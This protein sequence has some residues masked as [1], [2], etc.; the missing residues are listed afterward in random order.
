M[1][2]EIRE[3]Q[4]KT[5]IDNTPENAGQSGTTQAVGNSADQDKIIAACIEQIMEIL[6]SK[7]ER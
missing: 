1:P 4:I 3:L 7:N 2:I 5:I 6:K